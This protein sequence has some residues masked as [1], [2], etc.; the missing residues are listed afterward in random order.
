MLDRNLNR[1]SSGDPAV[2]VERQGRGLRSWRLIL[3]TETLLLGLCLYFVL[4]LNGP[5]WRALFADR[6]VSGLRDV[7]YGVAVGAALTA[8]HFAL[9]APLL[10]RWTTKPLLALL[11][12]AAASSSYFMGQYGIYL[13]PSMARNVLRTDIAE[14]SELLTARMMA[15]IFLLAL[16]PMLLLSRVTLRRRALAKSLG[17]RAVAI[18]IALLAGLGVLSLVF[19]DFSAQMRNHKEIR[20]LLAPASAVYAFA[21]VLTRDARVS[22]KPRRPIGMDAQ[23]GASWQKTK[24]PVLFVV[25]VGETARAAD[26]GLSGRSPNDTTPEL[27]RRTV[28]NFAEVTSC[29]SNTEV[30]LP[31]M[32]SAQGRRNYDEDAIKGS[33]SLLHVVKRAGL[34]VGWVD[35]Q[36]GCKGI[37]AGLPTWQ[38]DPPAMPEICDRERCL[39]EVLLDG[40]EGLMRRMPG[41]LMLVLHQLGNHGPAYYKRYPTK[42]ARFGPTC[43]TEDLSRCTREEIRNAYD[44]ALLYTD[45]VLASTIDWLKQLDRRYD[46]AMVYVSDHGESLGEN[47]LFLHG[48]P[49]AIAPREQTEVPMVMWFSPSFAQRAGLDIACLRARAGEAAS[50]D[51]LFP[52]VLGL[53]DVHTKIR[54]DALDLSARC[55]NA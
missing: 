45:H 52:T 24:K 40:A 10:N 4:V 12:V 17:V 20:Y 46:T 1:A 22:D 49:Y 28:I 8:A 7:G 21:S 55:R 36:S 47:G 3:S 42:F 31:C 39:D 51:N 43:G 34:N 53:L 37:C 2:P 50:H 6:P 30:S 9:L 33:E 16:P 23:L 14:A 32:F 13:D 48:M 15:S 19:K 44:N 35:N 25:V 18:L 27:A 29:G 41:S 11:A 5:F 26:W 54:D 38:P